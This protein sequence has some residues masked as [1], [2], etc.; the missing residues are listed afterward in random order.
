MFLVLQHIHYILGHCV[1]E[2]GRE[3]SSWC[4]STYIIPPMCGGG[5]EEGMFLMLQH[6]LYISRTLCGGV[7]REEGMFLFLQHIH[8]IPGH[9]VEE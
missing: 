2:R 8:Y 5:R 9:C 1:E 6:I 3:E 4:C 7:L